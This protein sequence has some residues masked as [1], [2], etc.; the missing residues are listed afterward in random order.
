MLGAQDVAFSEFPNGFAKKHII[1]NLRSYLYIPF[2]GIQ[3]KK[4]PAPWILF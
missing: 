4:G 2:A 1:S 3:P